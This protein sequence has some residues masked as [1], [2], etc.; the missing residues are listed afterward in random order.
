MF[1]VFFDFFFDHSAACV[2]IV[3]RSHAL[4][5]AALLVLHKPNP[6]H[7][8]GL[9]LV[10]KVDHLNSTFKVFQFIVLLT[11]FD[12][13][14]KFFKLLKTFRTILYQAVMTKLKPLYE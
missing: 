10:R 3:H 9:S 4:H 6:R 11:S 8:S 2:H 1:A 13:E 12:V 7:L 5:S 14:F